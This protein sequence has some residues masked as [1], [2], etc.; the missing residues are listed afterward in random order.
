MN[1]VTFILHSYLFIP[2]QAILH[3]SFFIPQA[4]FFMLCQAN[5]AGGEE[6][7]DVCLYE[8]HEEFE[9]VHEDAEEDADD[10][11]RR[12]EGC[13]TLPRDEDDARER[14]DDGMAG[15]DV[16]KETDGQRE[17]L[18]EHSDELYCR[19]D[20]QRCLEEHRYVGP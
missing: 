7:E 13:S 5:E 12:T 15:K 16:G 20:W 19:H 10:C 18:G 9:A 11:H 1:G 2:P 6:G 14:E 17:W 4:S 8:C 3:S